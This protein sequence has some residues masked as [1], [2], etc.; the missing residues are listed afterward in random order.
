MLDTD[1]IDRFFNW[2]GGLSLL[3]GNVAAARS[4][5]ITLGELMG[6][7]F[8]FTLSAPS[9]IMVVSLIG[10][11]LFIVEKVVLLR[12]R[13]LEEKILKAKDAAT[14]KEDDEN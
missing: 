11:I 2:V 1:I 5:P 4:G 7:L 9:A 3:G 10:G 8:S 13:K 12:I 14:K 6:E